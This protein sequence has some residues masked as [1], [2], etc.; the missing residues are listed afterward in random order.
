MKKNEIIKDMSLY[1]AS[2][3]W[4]EHDFGGFQDATE[5]KDFQFQLKK[6]KYVG[7]D[8]VLYKMIKKQAQKLH[9]NE[10]NLINDWLKE[11]VG[12]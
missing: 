12:A 3:Y 1:E 10:D 7:I 6:K 4:D 11:K 2:D 8:K 5:I 9:T